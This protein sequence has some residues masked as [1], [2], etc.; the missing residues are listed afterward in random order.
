[1][2]YENLSIFHK[3]ISSSLLIQNLA[4]SEI[5]IS[6]VIL[7]CLIMER[8]VAPRAPMITISNI[9][10]AANIG[11][12]GLRMKIAGPKVLVRAKNS[13]DSAAKWM[14]SMKMSIFH[15]VHQMANWNK[16]HR[17]VYE[18]ILW[19]AIWKRRPDTPL[20]LCKLKLW[21]TAQRW[22]ISGLVETRTSPA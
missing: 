16:A 10:Y 4:L 20:K 12:C 13:S 7:V 14:H 9:D 8:A 11:H 17:Y 6:R 22:L 1:M 3:G 15:C 2:K 18:A 19:M 5:F 21:C